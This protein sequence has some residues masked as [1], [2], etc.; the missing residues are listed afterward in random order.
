MMTFKPGMRYAVFS[1]NDRNAKVGGGP[2]RSTWTKA[3]TARVNQ[4][5]SINIYLNV[6]PLDGK[7]QIRET[8]E[9]PG[10]VDVEP[11]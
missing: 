5:G 2:G 9:E 4:D 1:I 10:T 8:P 3:G 7:L 11:V 6:L